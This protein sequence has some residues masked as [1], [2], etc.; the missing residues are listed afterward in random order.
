MV[1]LFSG[2]APL[3]LRNSYACK[4]INL[5]PTTTPSFTRDRQFKRLFENK[6]LL[7]NFLHAMRPCLQDQVRDITFLNPVHSMP[8]YKQV[9]FDLF[10]KDQDERF[11]IIEL[12]N[13]IEPYFHRR[14]IHYISRVLSTQLMPGQDYR[15]MSSV[16]LLGLLNYP[17]SELRDC[18]STAIKTDLFSLHLFSIYSPIYD[19]S[20]DSSRSQKWLYFIKYFHL[21]NKIPRAFAE[22]PEFSLAVKIA[23]ELIAE[24]LRQVKTTVAPV[25]KVAERLS[26]VETTVPLVSKTRTANIEELLTQKKEGESLCKKDQEHFW[27]VPDHMNVFLDPVLKE[28][29]CDKQP[30]QFKKA[31]PVLLKDLLKRVEVASRLCRSPSRF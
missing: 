10:F 30:G 11:Y 19:L 7:I 8:G 22:D 24:E 15:Q 26:S 6:E 4:Q 21:L 13:A 16:S 28:V 25:T 12:Q 9:I 14:A 17:L 2:S 27:C 5:F 31:V 1:L 29:S 20:L 3:F 18:S 23:T